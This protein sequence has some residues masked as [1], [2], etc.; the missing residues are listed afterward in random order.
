MHAC[1]NLNLCVCVCVCDFESNAESTSR[2]CNRVQKG[3]LP[4]TRDCERRCKR[5]I[6]W[7]TQFWEEGSSPVA[8]YG[9]VI[10][11]QVA[12]KV[13]VHPAESEDVAGW[14]LIERVARVIRRQKE[15]VYT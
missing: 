11:I 3:V 10:S 8:S 13:F 15:R 7:L 6:S 9:K 5:L 2:L 1:L 4:W 12:T 14:K